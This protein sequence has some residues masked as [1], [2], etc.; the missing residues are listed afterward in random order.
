MFETPGI[1]CLNDYFLFLLIYVYFLF[2]HFLLNFFRTIFDQVPIQCLQVP[3]FAPMI[4]YNS[5]YKNA[6]YNFVFTIFFI[7]LN[8]MH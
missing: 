3:T 8:K 4:R 6:V 5:V 1:V 2:K 7:Y